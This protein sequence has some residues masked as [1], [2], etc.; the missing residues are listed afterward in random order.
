MILLFGIL[1]FLSFSV[2]QLKVYA[3]YL[4]IE[5][6]IRSQFTDVFELDNGRFD[7]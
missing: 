3:S 7:R 6:S 5:P 2:S 1:D 4:I